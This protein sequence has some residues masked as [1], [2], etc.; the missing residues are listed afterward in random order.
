M[1]Q[2]W[3][4]RY[5]SKKYVY[6]E[7]PNNFFREF[8]DNQP[9]GKILLPAEGEGRNAVY[10][11]KSDWE[12]TAVDFSEQGKEK[13]LDLAKK[14]NVKINYIVTDIMDLQLNESKFDAIALIYAHFPDTIR[15]TVHR[16][17]ISL[18]KD[19][20]VFILEAF[21]KQQINNNTGGPKNINMLYDVEDLVDDFSGLKIHTLNK[22]DIHRKEGDFHTGIANIIQLK[23][24]REK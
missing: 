9:P 5:T 3:D 21:S 11:A 12:V 6:G 20:G 7:E 24:I 23:A 22:L 13:A 18:L 4:D 16:K 2:F 17:L 14:H 19:Q 10:A 1:H 15:Q 8:I